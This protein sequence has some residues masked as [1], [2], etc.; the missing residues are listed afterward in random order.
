MLPDINGCLVYK[1]SIYNPLI[2]SFA[3]LKWGYAWEAS[4]SLA[5]KHQS[6][7]QPFTKYS[8]F[9]GSLEVF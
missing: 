5:A 2:F 8:E 4:T 9:L 3:R 7:Y 6:F 1:I